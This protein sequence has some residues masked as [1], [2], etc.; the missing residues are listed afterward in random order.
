[1]LAPRIGMA[2]LAAVRVQT[3]DLAVKRESSRPW[4]RRRDRVLQ[5][6]PLCRMCKAIGKVS[7]AVEVDH[8]IPL[9]MGGSN[10]DA[11]LQPLCHKHHAE[12]TAKENAE[13]NGWDDSVVAVY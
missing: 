7:E 8:I 6:E 9:V 12:K 4:K 1:M 13:L 5:R 11:N 2:P 3:G 10:D